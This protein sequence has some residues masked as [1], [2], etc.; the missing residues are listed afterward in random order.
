MKYI[1]LFLLLILN[2]FAIPDEPVFLEDSTVVIKYNNSNARV[3]CNK[4][5]LL[6]KKEFISPQF[7]KSHK[8]TRTAYYP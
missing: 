3:S 8:A 5:V 7:H 1:I 2:N 6:V 4:L